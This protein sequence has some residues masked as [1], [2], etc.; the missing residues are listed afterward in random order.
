M[1]E[2]YHSNIYSVEIPYEKA[3]IWWNS[4]IVAFMVSKYHIT[5]LPYGVSTP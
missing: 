3:P 4:T 5:R 1:V 2:Q